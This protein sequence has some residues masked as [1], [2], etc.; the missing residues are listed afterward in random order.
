MP[1]VE[2]PSVKGQR[3]LTFLCSSQEM[4]PTDVWN[5]LESSTQD[6]L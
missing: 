2:K 4:S 1:G 6:L 3:T 5:I